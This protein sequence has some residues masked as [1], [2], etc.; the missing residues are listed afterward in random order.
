MLE[1]ARS[2]LEDRIDKMDPPVPAPSTVAA[3]SGSSPLPTLKPSTKLP[4]IKIKTFDGDFTKW[5]EFWDNF[6][7]I[8]D[9]RPGI[10][11]VEKMQHL[12]GALIGEPG[13]LIQGLT[14]TNSNYKVAIELLTERYNNKSL[15]IDSHVE[16][17]LHLPSVLK[18]NTSA[19]I[20]QLCL[21]VEENVHALENLSVPVNS[22]SIMIKHLMRTALSGDV[23]TEVEKYLLREKSAT[24][25]DLIKFLIDYASILEPCPG[26]VA[27]T[28]GG[29]QQKHGGTNKNGP[30]RSLKTEKDDFVIECFHCDGDHYFSACPKLKSLPVAKRKEIVMSLK[31][32]MNCLSSRH[33]MSKCHKRNLCSKCKGRHHVLLHDDSK[34][35]DSDSN[36]SDQSDRSDTKLKTGFS[37]M[38]ETACSKEVI[39]ATAIVNLK[40]AS[41]SWIKA[42]VLID[43]G[44]QVSLV[45]HGMV[46]KL[47]VDTSDCRLSLS[48][49]TGRNKNISKSVKLNIY[50]LNQNDNLS[51]INLYVINQI[52]KNLPSNHINIDLD[53]YNH[54]HELDLADREF[55]VPTQI[56]ILLGSDI[57]ATLLREGLRFFKDDYV[58]LCAQRTIFGWVILGCVG[59]SDESVSASS[60]HINVINEYDDLNVTLKKFW[61]IEEVC[62]SDIK[63]WSIDEKKCEQFYIDTVSRDI[64]GRYVVRLPWKEGP[65]LGES[66]AIAMKRLTQVEK[67]LGSNIHAYGKVI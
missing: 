8:V 37:G 56:E 32:C 14:L 47:G 27:P 16:K 15:I 31:L 30:K 63:P 49:I 4:P 9:K 48:G 10:S 23:H 55:T 66:R 43:P 24:V 38:L 52:S 13:T 57:Y 42:R 51:N 61:Q 64:D 35:K 59:S 22:W 28:A 2:L 5:Q 33:F 50:S 45:T 26:S 41:G 17:L 40:T 29:S 62:N 65:P 54:M 25:K 6:E 46:K 18:K 21:S 20:R 58:N 39:L 36:K 1:E 7:C 53:M 19:D 60:Y 12:K 11:E 44:S 3:T 67:K 34:S